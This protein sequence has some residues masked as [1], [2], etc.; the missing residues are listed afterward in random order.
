M[1][2][3]FFVRVSPGANVFR[4][5]ASYPTQPDFK[6]F[7][8]PNLHFQA[9][10]GSV[11]VRFSASDVAR[12][13]DGMYRAV[14]SM[15]NKQQAAVA[16]ME[17]IRFLVFAY[18][19]LR[20]GHAPAPRRQMPTAPRPSAQRPEPAASARASARPGRSSWAHHSSSTSR[21]KPR[22]EADSSG[23]KAHNTHRRV[24]DDKPK[25]APTHSMSMADAFKVLNLPVTAS[26]AEVRKAYH[27]G[28]LIHHPDKGGDAEKF[29]VL[30]QAYEKAKVKFE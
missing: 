20:A 18:A 11:P 29:K 17:A 9:R 24:P 16:R 8:E 14:M 13:R 30:N 21:S 23:A 25:Q 5:N 28:A 4:T 26:L 1:P 27:K 15:Q 10:A 3:N 6:R 19:Q 7:F 2:V 22:P 12:A